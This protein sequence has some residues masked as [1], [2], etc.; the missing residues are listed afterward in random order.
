VIG[1]SEWNE[2][3]SDLRWSEFS[4]LDGAALLD[5]LRGAITRA[6]VPEYLT[7]ENSY[8]GLMHACRGADG[9]PVLMSTTEGLCNAGGLL[10]QNVPLMKERYALDGEDAWRGLF[11]GYQEGSY[12]YHGWYVGRGADGAHV[13]GPGLVGGSARLGGAPLILTAQ[14]FNELVMAVN[15][16]CLL[17]WRH[18]PGN[19]DSVNGF[20]YGAT[21]QEAYEACVVVADVAEGVCGPDQW[22]CRWGTSR[23]PSGEY[24]AYTSVDRWPVL[25]FECG[26]V[27]DETPGGADETRYDVTFGSEYLLHGPPYERALWPGHGDTVEVE[28]RILFFYLPHDY[29]YVDNLVV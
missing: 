8:I 11:G 12:I 22:L 18:L 20:G 9:L 24:V 15:M 27:V 16:C 21:M 29:E 19:S 13:Y 26:M 6:E 17:A 3:W 5:G 4:G 14:H 7:R 23:P 28:S 25:P 2:I 1:E 10:T